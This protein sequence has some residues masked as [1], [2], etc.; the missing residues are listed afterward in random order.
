MKKGIFVDFLGVVGVANEDQ[1]HLAV[2]AR[3]EQIQQGEEALG[4]VLLVLVHR[5]RDIHQAEH[6]R[7]RD[8][9]G[10]QHTI[11]VAQVWFLKKRQPRAPTLEALEFPIELRSVFRL[12]DGDRQRGLRLDRLHFAREPASEGDPAC[13]RLR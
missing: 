12:S 6:R 4:E 1:F 9:L 5:G 8:R 2:L 10:P 3:K 7:A 11:A 13:Q